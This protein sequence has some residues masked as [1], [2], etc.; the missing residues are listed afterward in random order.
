MQRSRRCR[1]LHNRSRLPQVPWAKACFRPLAGRRCHAAHSILVTDAFFP[2]HHSLCLSCHASCSS[3]RQIPTPRSVT[4][5]ATRAAVLGVFAMPPLGGRSRDSPSA[6]LAAPCCTIHSL[7]MN[8]ASAFIARGAGANAEVP[9][10]C[11]APRSSACL[12]C[13]RRRGPEVLGGME[14][15]VFSHAIL[16]S[17]VIT[18]STKVWP[19]PN[20]P[21]LGYS[22]RVSYKSS[23]HYGSKNAITSNRLTKI[24]TGS[25]KAD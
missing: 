19:I 1:V 17:K 14:I 20:L 18:S 5:A 8:A 10:R 11:A 9:R 25:N 24:E 6:H 21:S 7:P 13:D 23:P 3:R 16:M 2:F 4:G 22:S 15:G 12:P